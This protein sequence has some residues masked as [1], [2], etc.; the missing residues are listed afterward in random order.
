MTNALTPSPEQPGLRKLSAK[1]QSQRATALGCLANENKVNC[2]QVLWAGVFFDGTNNN[3][4]RDLVDK[5]YSNIAVLHNAFR[6]SRKSGYFRFYIPGLGTRFPE[7]GEMSES[8]DGKAMGAGGDSRVYYAMIQVYNCIHEAL[9]DGV[10]LVSPEETMTVV[11]SAD[12]GLKTVWLL[13]SSKRMAYFA[14][15]ETRLASAIKNKRPNIKLV[16][17]SVFG[18]SR[19]AAEARAFCNWL[20]ACCREQVGGYTLCGIPIR[21][22]FLGIFDTVASVGLADSSPVGSGFLDWADGTMKVPLSIERCVHLVAAHEIRASFPLSSG[23]DDGAYPENCTEVVYPGAHCDVGGGYSPGDQGKAKKGR[24]QL[25]SQIPLVKM[26]LEAQKTGVPLLTLR[27]L[28]DLRDLETIEDLQIDGELAAR[29]TEYEK[30]SRIQ[31]KT[32]EHV[33]FEHMRLYW[34]WRL[35]VGTKIHELD[36]YKSANAQDKEDLLASESDFLADIRKIERLR[37]NQSPMGLDMSQLAVENE[38]SK[39]LPVPIGVSQFFDQHIHD[40]HASFLLLGPITADDRQVAIRKIKA[41]KAAGK[42]LNK[43]EKRALATNAISPGNFPVMRDSDLQ[44]LHD[45]SGWSSSVAV[46]A[47]TDTRRESGGHVRRRRVFD[48]S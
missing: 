37:R 9:F 16:N 8:D 20:I 36:S 2:E 27:E 5:S 15:L 45:M 39:K 12:K 26:Y 14:E 17:L 42:D 32:V 10:A 4:E 28:R 44:D 48:K 24:S 46:S 35:H 29:F 6:N 47:I 19:G 18:F 33:L 3:K 23:R 21:F 38:L 7:I 11:T 31:S 34:R 30:W 1:E 41:K 22:Q 40:S 13:G 25:A 43:L